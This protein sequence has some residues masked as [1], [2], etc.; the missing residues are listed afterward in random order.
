MGAT[1]ITPA[2]TTQDELDALICNIY[3][4]QDSAISTDVEY[5]NNGGMLTTAW[6]VATDGVLYYNG[7]SG[8]DVD[9][10][11][12]AA[13]GKNSDPEEGVEMSDSCFGHPGAGGEFHY[14]SASPCTADPSRGAADQMTAGEEYDIL[15]TIK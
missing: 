5:T 6:G 12:P 11:I 10:I 9:P 13:Y 4:S 2:P 8:E 15:G 14:H 7:I 3:R 1:D